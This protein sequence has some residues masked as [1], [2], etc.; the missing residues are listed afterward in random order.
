MLRDTTKYSNCTTSVGIRHILVRVIIL[1]EIAICREGEKK[2]LSSIVFKT[3]IV[4]II[5]ILV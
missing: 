2:L 5:R 1:E 3:S 4:A